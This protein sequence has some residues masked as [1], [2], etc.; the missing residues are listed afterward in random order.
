VT[1]VI[2]ARGVSGNSRNAG[3]TLIELL[4][5]LAV[6]SMAL[7]LL[8]SLFGSSYTLGNEVRHRRVASEVAEEV[9]AEIRRDPASFTWPGTVTDQLAP[10][11][12][13]SEIGTVE[14]PGVSATH[15]R[16]DQRVRDLYGAFRWRAFVRLA[17]PDAPTCELTVLVYWVDGGKSQRFTLTTLAPRT[18]LEAKQ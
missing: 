18:L 14:L 9:L 15:I 16:D 10:I 5:S 8:V 7:Y 12:R 1:S 2:R 6:L 17:T 13:G 3:F 4:V 11:T